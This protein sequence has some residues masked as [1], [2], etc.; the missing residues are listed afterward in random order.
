MTSWRLLD[1]PPLSAAENMALDETLVELRGEG[2][3]PNTIHFLQ[4][5]QGDQ[6][7]GGC[8][9]FKNAGYSK[10][11]AKDFQFVSH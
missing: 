2:K 7:P 1:T 10:F 5:F 9:L 6:D 11:I 4:F 3:T 8:P